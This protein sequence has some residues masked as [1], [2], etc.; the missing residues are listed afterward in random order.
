MFKV[1]SDPDP[2]VIGT[3]PAETWRWITGQNTSELFLWD[4]D[5]SGG[6]PDEGAE[7]AAVLYYSMSLPLW[8]D[9]PSG[10]LS[11]ICEN[12]ATGVCEYYAYILS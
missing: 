12:K 10:Y 3:N 1:S 4:G 8:H 11:Y 6:Q 2:L 5:S 9:H 7:S